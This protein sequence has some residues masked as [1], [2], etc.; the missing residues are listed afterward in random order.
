MRTPLIMIGVAF[1]ICMVA[2]GAYGGAGGSGNEYCLA[3]HGGQSQ[4]L[5]FADGDSVSTRIDPKAYSGSAHGSLACTRCHSDFSAEQHPQRTFRNRSQYQIKASRGCR[6]CHPDGV[7]RSRAI[8]GALF[9]KERAGEPVI[10]GNCHSAHTAARVSAGAMSTS[11]EKYCLSCHS[12]EGRMSFSNGESLSLMVRVQEVRDSAHKQVACSDCHFGFSADEH[13]RKLFRSVREYRH[14]SSEMC[15]RCHFDKYSKVSEGIHYALLSVGRLDTP[16]CAD[17][18]GGHAVSSPGKKRLSIVEKCKTCHGEV[19][20]AYARSVHGKALVQED[21]RDVPTCI[22]CHMS[23]NIKDPYSADFHDHI[24]DTCSNCHSNAS[25]M[26]KYGLSTDVV[27]TYLSDF[28]GMTLGL[29]RK[30]AQRHDRP[31]QAMAVCT[32]CHG[33]HGITRASGEN[34]QAVKSRLLKRCQQ[35]HPGATENFPDA[36]LSHYQ[37]SFKVAPV[38]FAIDQFYKIMMPLMVAGLLIQIILDIRRYLSDR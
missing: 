23:H 38:V 27:K 7:L 8:H 21:N 13:P 31:N 36:W 6:D 35:C 15:R 16:N 10:C 17:C 5:K 3:C 18:H 28:H 9:K 33:T 2:A 22:D 4:P 25:I 1:A 19:A 29:Y 26:R 12:S 20:A 14:S 30:E 34:T 24:P 32:D 37:P 11:E